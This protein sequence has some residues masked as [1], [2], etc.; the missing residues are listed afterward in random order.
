[1]LTGKARRPEW[2]DQSEML[3]LWKSWSFS[4]W[5]NWAQEGIHLPK[6]LLNCSISSHVKID[7]CFP[8]CV[9]DTGATN[10]VMRTITAHRVQ[11]NPEKPVVDLGNTREEVLRLGT[12]CG[13]LVN[14]LI[15]GLYAAGIRWNLLSVFALTGFNFN[16]SVHDNSIKIYLDDLLYGCAH[17]FDGLYI[18][19]TNDSSYNSSCIASY[20]DVVFHSIISHAKLDHVGQNRMARSA[21]GGF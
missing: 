5:V 14:W 4:P 20:D 21:R 7:H 6:S 3:Q 9:I 19:D 2:K 16:F 12:W 1:M 11:S 15:W 13:L 10:H 18:L 17:S 8:D